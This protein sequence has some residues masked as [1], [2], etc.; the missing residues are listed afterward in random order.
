MSHTSIK[1]TKEQAIEAVSWMLTEFDSP[2][3]VAAVKSTNGDPNQLIG[4]LFE[5]QGHCMEK[6]GINGDDEGFA[7]F[8]KQLGQYDEMEEFK[9]ISSQL[10]HKM[11][12]IMKTFEADVDDEDEEVGDED[13]EVEDEDEDEDVDQDHNENFKDDD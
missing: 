9:P 11:K 5:V 12:A 1:L 8:A 13:E 2:H 7:L 3:V 10:K 6:Y 4:I